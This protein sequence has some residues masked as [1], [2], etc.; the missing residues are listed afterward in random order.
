MTWQT[1]WT[2]WFTEGL[3]YEYNTKIHSHRVRAIRA[4]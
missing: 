1:A 3:Q 4:F 2:Q